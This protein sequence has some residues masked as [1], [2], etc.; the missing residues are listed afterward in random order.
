[1]IV[2]L[3]SPVVPPGVYRKFHK[4]WTGPYVVVEKLSD[5]NYK[6]RP[7]TG[8]GKPIVHYNQLKKCDPDIRFPQTNTCNS[9]PVP[10]EVH[11]GN[12]PRL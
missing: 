7:L 1:M 3:H 5:L 4:P 9:Q 12:N 8:N 6:I 11:I 2:W 10:E